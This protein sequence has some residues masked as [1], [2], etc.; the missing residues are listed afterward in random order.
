MGHKGSNKFSGAKGQKKPM[1]VMRRLEAE[2]NALEILDEAHEADIRDLAKKHGPK[3]VNTL[4]S[5][6]RNRRTP[7]SVKRQ[8]ARDLIEIGHG[9]VGQ[10]DA[11]EASTSGLVINIVSLSDADKVEVKT[12]S[13]QKVVV[14]RERK[15]IEEEV[16]SLLIPDWQPEEQAQLGEHKPREELSQVEGPT[17]ATVV[18]FEERLAARRAICAGQW[19]PKAEAG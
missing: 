5:L 18:G 19:P 17:N 12:L 9:R 11:G 3:A 13:P 6:M 15:S 16:P 2:E 14:E 1:E 8:C 4:A 10:K 7:P